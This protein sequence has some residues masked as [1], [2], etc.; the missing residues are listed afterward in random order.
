M[1]NH[2]LINIAKQALNVKRLPVLLGKVFQRLT[3]KKQENNEANLRWLAQQQQD[4]AEYAQSLDAELWQESLAYAKSL[5]AHANKVLSNID[6]TLG[7]GGFY[8]LIYFVTRYLKPQTVVETGVAA[9]Y[10]SHAFL[11]GL[12]K[13]AD[14]GADGRLFSSDFPYF[15]I[16]NPEKYIGILV[17]EDLKARWHLF[18]DGDAKNLS[19]IA[20]SVS[21]VDLFHYDSDKRYAGRE[22]AMQA[23][24]TKLS[25]NALIIMD[26]INDNSF[27]MDL[28]LSEQQ[29]QPYRIFEFGGKYIGM[30]GELALLKR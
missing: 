29:K 3:D 6:V 18:I 23:L 20:Q 7:G 9:G 5:E 4:F 28:C 8:P 15:R 14:S 2:V 16:E 1:S 13:N 17:P 21:S 10:S 12:Q 24:K 25:D 30:L 11:S 27:F 26:D 22:Q 19:K